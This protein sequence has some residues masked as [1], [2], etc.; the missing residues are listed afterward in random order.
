MRRAIPVLLVAIL[1]SPGAVS[2]QTSQSSTHTADPATE[3]PAAEVDISKLGVSL[4][5]I[6]RELAQAEAAAVAPE[7]GRLKF[8]ITVQVVGS[9]PKINVLE[10]FPVSGA[11]PYGPP[12]HQEVLDV[13]TPQE[14]RSPAVPFS[15][16]AVWAAKALMEKSKKTRCEEELAAYKALVMQGV[17]VA[18]P[19]CTQ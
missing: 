11:V 12:T 17:A 4:S 15:A 19:R 9:A 10:G 8:S 14:F 13:L 2:A 7:D 5:R 18:A 3:A 1:A 6:K 16:L